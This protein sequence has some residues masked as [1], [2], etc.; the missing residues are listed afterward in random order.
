MFLMIP[1]KQ[2]HQIRNLTV[3]K[4]KYLLIEI[5]KLLKRNEIDNRL[6]E[7]RKK[8]KESSEAGPLIILL[9]WPITLLKNKARDVGHGDVISVPAFVN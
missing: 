9:S 2:T 7:E 3:L 5:G 6:M 4:N 8:E 1:P